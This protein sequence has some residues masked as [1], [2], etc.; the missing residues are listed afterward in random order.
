MKQA[1]KDY[2]LFVLVLTLLNIAG[3][4]AV[5]LPLPFFLFKDKFSYSTLFLSAFIPLLIL[6]PFLPDKLSLIVSL[7]HYGSLVIPTLVMIF[8][9]RY[10]NLNS[11]QRLFISSLSILVF[12]VVLGVIS[13]YFLGKD[14]F[15]ALFEQFF[16]TAKMSENDMK[17]IKN[18][19]YYAGYGLVFFSEAMFFLF[20]TVFFSK[21]TGVLRDF[22][23]YKADV[24]VVIF[25]VVFIL[26]VNMLW[27]TGYL[28]GY[29]LQIVATLSL[30][31]FFIFFVQGFS[32]YLYFLNKVGFSGF[33]KVLSIVLIFIYP[34]PA[35][36][37]LV[38]ILDFWLDFR[39][40]ISKIG[41]GKLV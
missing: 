11:F 41:G 30:F 24:F 16:K 39:V 33:A 36:L 27:I 4:L 2:L 37:A 21:A 29:I 32:I 7:L 25:T 5:F 13:N 28:H 20:N 1:I 18:V 22:E 34:L 14:F 6:F 40:R 15:I 10:S 26:C 17:Y 9:F 19:F 31:L 23:G 3:P 35:I 12:I 38:G 8:L